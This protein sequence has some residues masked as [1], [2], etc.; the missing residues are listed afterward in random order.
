MAKLARVFTLHNEYSCNNMGREPCVF[1][2][3]QKLLNIRKKARPDGIQIETNEPVY[4]IDNATTKG[5]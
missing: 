2:I 4:Q 5:K 3:F 1:Y